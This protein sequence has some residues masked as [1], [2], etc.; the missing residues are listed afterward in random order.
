MSEPEWYGTEFNNTGLVHYME[1]HGMNLAD[2]NEYAR[3]FAHLSAAGLLQK[4]PEGN[5]EP[6][7]ESEES[8]LEQNA[9]APK[10]VIPRPSRTSTGISSRD[11]SGV[12]PRPSTRLKYSREQLAAMGAAEYKNLMQ[13]DGVELLRC[14]KWYSEHPV[15]RRA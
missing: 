9:P 11:I 13:T 7:P 3:A 12:P 1:V 10:A 15:S 5:G 14:E 6:Q 8:D 4:R 2:P